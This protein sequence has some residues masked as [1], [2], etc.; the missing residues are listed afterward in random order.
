[1]VVEP[2][3]SSGPPTGEVAIPESASEV[4]HGA[5]LRCVWV[6]ALGTMTFAVV[7]SDRFL[8]WS[9]MQGEADLCGEAE[10]MRWARRYATVPEVVDCGTAPDGSAWLLTGALEGTSAVAE[11]WKAEPRRAVQALG[12]GLRALHES[13]PV[14]R[15]PFSWSTE[16]RLSR[17]L[18]RA[19][20]GLLDPESWDQAHRGLTVDQALVAVSDPPPV[21]FLVVCHGDACA[22]NTLIGD[23]G[24]CTGHVDLGSLGT[25]DRWADLAVATW[26]TEWN[27]G[28]GWDRELLAAYGIAPDPDRTRYHRLLW[29]LAD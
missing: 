6:N 13:L 22:P 5:R 1:M 8:K 28:P 23:D 27:Y 10:R 15:C 16:D 11:R 18:D 2:W 25:G 12:E 17:A 29:D 26:S 4:V 14:A 19:A 3:T 7:G 24:H 9:P 20:A 21:D